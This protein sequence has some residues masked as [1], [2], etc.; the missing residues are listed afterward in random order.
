MTLNSEEGVLHSDLGSPVTKEV[1]LRYCVTL[2]WI[3]LSFQPLQCI[4]GLHGLKEDSVMLCYRLY[5]YSLGPSRYHQKH[6]YVYT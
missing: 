3:W 6:I 5:E 4:S 1:Y 2:A